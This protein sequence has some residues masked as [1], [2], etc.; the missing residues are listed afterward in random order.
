MVHYSDDRVT[1]TNPPILTFDSKLFMKGNSIEE[2]SA[3]QPLSSVA[4]DL[5]SAAYEYGHAWNLEWLLPQLPGQ[6]KLTQ[7]KVSFQDELWMKHTVNE[8]GLK[9]VKTQPSHFVRDPLHIPIKQQEELI[10]PYKLPSYKQEDILELTAAG[11]CYSSHKIAPATNGSR[12]LP[13]SAISCADPGSA[14]LKGWILFQCCCVYQSRRQTT[15]CLI[16]EDLDTQFAPGGFQLLAKPRGRAQ[17]VWPGQ[18]GAPMFSGR[19]HKHPA[20]GKPETTQKC[21]ERGSET[22]PARVARHLRGTGIKSF[23]S[24]QYGFLNQMPFPSSSPSPSLPL[25]CSPFLR[26]GYAWQQALGCHFANLCSTLFFT[27]DMLGTQGKPAVPLFP[28]A[29]PA[30]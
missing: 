1:P 17:P 14:G 12:N 25:L 26:K 29:L 23:E 22:C 10:S 28:L 8:M 13:F 15:V 11:G 19:E 21:P 27:N 30:K 6:A 9:C 7:I 4:P 16:W 2:S 3:Q 20:K 5:A 24:D 18:I